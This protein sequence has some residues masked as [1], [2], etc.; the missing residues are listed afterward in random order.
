MNHRP[1]QL[2]SIVQQA[3]TEFF[4]KEIEWPSNCL[5]TVTNVETTNDCKIAFIKV[6]V[7]PY[8]QTGTVLKLLQQH[9]GRLRTFL[10]KR[11]LLRQAP[12]IRFVVDKQIEMIEQID[13]AIKNLDE[14]GNN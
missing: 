5:A 7:L 8:K 2:S 9:K 10:S 13:K 11:V 4:V 12:E 3:I 6:S 1:E 14:A